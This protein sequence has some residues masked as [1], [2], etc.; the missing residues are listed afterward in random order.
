METYF[1][2]MCGRS[3]IGLSPYRCPAC[4][5]D[6]Q[7]FIM[8]NK[9]AEEKEENLSLNYFKKNLRQRLFEM[10]VARYQH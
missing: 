9:A 10:R 4:G 2:I 1:C 7:H 8:I 5:G 6:K 3:G